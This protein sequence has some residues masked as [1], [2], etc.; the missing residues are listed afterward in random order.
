MVPLAKSVAFDV[1]LL[2]VAFVAG[3]VLKGQENFLCK[4]RA[5]LKQK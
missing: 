2:A 3:A 1:M 4:R 5:P